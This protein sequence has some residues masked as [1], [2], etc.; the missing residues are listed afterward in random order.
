[1]AVCV[2]SDRDEALRI[3]H[4]QWAAPGA[5]PPR[6]SA[7]LRVGADFQ[8][9]ADLVTEAQVAEKVVCEAD[10]DEHLARIQEFANAGF[11]HV[12]VH[13]IGDDQETLFRFYEDEI[14]PR[15][16]EL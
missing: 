1:M 12:F 13:Q 10:A 3:A 11:D 7:K 4:A 6:L 14:L 9:V 8:A 15:A 16:T 5:T 2:A